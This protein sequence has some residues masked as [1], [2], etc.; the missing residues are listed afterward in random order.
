MAEVEKPQTEKPQESVFLTRVFSYSV[1]TNAIT[2][3]KDLYSHAKEYSL[4]RY[5][6]ERAEENLS[7]GYKWLAPR[8]QPVLENPTVQKYSQKAENLGCA[9]L[10]KLDQASTTL[11]ETFAQSSKTVENSL[12]TVTQSVNTK[13]DTLDTYLR[14]SLLAFPLNKTLDITE[15]VVNMIAEEPETPKEGKQEETKDQVAAVVPCGPIRRTQILSKKLQREAMC[16]LKHLT[17]RSQERLQSMTH[18]DLI[19]YAHNHID[20]GIKMTNQFFTE[21]YKKVKTGKEFISNQQKKLVAN[22]RIK[23]IR[24]SV[25]K[26]TFEA[27]VAL[28]NA[29]DALGQQLQLKNLAE[30]T[31]N[32][33][34]F[35]YFAPGK[36]F[37]LFSDAAAKSKATLQSLLDTLHSR[38]PA[39]KSILTSTLVGVEQALQHLLTL[40]RVNKSDKQEEKADEEEEQEEEEEE[41]ENEEEE[42]EEEKKT[43]Q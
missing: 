7:Q 6:C 18:V 22:P 3:S 26:A 35:Q 32:L 4:V 10:D 27:V 8:L 24:Q 41:E 25:G 31:R 17:M 37:Q 23:K 12:A 5:G 38:T 16:K 42:E 9:A 11:N 19:Q 40:F 15:K 13:I 20:S 28:S 34:A 36:S 39:D 2:F 29:V 30:R 43:Q 14:D 33:T 1:V 21:S